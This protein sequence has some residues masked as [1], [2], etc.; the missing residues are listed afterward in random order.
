MKRSA[1]QK[2]RATF[3]RAK[4]KLQAFSAA[5][6]LAEKLEHWEDFLED[7]D[8][9]FEKLSRGTKKNKHSY[10]W[11]ADQK[12]KRINDEVMNYVRCARNEKKHGIDELS[13]KLPAFGE[14]IEPPAE[15]MAKV[16]SSKIKLAPDGLW[17]QFLKLADGRTYPVE[18]RYRNAPMLLPTT[19]ME[20]DKI[21]D[22]PRHT[23]N[24]GSWSSMHIVEIGDYAVRYTEMMLREAEGQIIEP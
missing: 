14:T 19:V 12:E 2:A 10:Q 6:D 3:D 1:V 5:N 15:I 4:R 21:I 13:F 22:V 18:R 24:D 7:H 17:T 9:I 23:N 11:L 8:S 16:V 20:R